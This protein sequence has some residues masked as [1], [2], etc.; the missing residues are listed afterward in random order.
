VRSDISRSVA[1]LYL[2]EAGRG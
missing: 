2:M 1:W